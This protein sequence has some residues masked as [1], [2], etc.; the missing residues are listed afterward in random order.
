[1]NQKADVLSKLA[2]VA[3]NHLT[4]KVLVEE[5]GRRKNMK[6]DVYEPRL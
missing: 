5:C 3:F 6:H 4:K 2:S 1:M